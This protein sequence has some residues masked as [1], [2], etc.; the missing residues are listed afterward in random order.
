MDHPKTEEVSMGHEEA[1]FSFKNG[2]QAEDKLL[3]DPKTGKENAE[4]VDAGLTSKK[5]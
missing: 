5:C 4:H 2:Q 3:D 1:D